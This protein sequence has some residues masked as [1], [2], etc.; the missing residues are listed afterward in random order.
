MKLQKRT[1]RRKKKMKLNSKSSQSIQH[2]TSRSKTSKLSNKI[3]QPNEKDAPVLGFINIILANN[4]DPSILNKIDPIS[5][6]KSS[7]MQTTIPKNEDD[8]T[9]IE[10][11]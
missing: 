2:T 4:V 5:L 7:L 11:R 3:I 10:R 6:V 8:S 9:S 1:R